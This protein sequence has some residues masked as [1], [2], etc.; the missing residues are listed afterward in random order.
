MEE[1][2]MTFA[3]LDALAA[4]LQ[5]K[6]R[7][8]SPTDWP[9]SWLGNSPSRRFAFFRPSAPRATPS[10][11]RPSKSLET[12]RKADDNEGATRQARNERPGASPPVQYVP[13]PYESFTIRGSPLN[14]ARSSAEKSSGSSQAAKCPPLSTSLK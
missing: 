7:E 10:A 3:Q 14:A 5:A 13:E 8:L 11:L 1:R 9:R 6:R 2:Q 4:E 12:R